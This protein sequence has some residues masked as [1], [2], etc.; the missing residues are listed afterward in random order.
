MSEW[1]ISRWLKLW[2]FFFAESE[3]NVKVK[4]EGEIYLLKYVKGKK[5]EGMWKMA[6]S[7]LIWRLWFKIYSDCGEFGKFFTTFC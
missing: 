5:S 3:W 7:Q 4:L 6:V 2:F 1:K